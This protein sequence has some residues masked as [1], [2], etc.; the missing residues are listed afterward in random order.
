M[1]FARQD[2]P[3]RAEP[4]SQHVADRLEAGAVPARDG[5]LRERGFS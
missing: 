1:S 4:L 3:E 2:R 5:E